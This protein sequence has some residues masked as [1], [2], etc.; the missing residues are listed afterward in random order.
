MGFIKPQRLEHRDFVTPSWLL[1]Q[2]GEE[3][4]M[5]GCL[6]PLGLQRLANQNP[7]LAFYLS[8]LTWGKG[9]T[10]CRYC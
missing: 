6:L 2:T 9:K 7:D 5:V 4:E 3:L 10:G 1:N 8:F